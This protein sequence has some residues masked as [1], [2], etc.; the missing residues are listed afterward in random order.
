MRQYAAVALLLMEL[1]QHNTEGAARLTDIEARRRTEHVL[2]TQL[3]LLQQWG[4]MQVRPGGRGQYA[5][6]PP[7]A[8]LSPTLRRPCSQ[9]CTP[10]PAVE[11]VPGHALHY[12]IILQ[13]RHSLQCASKHI[14]GLPRC[15]PSALLLPPSVLPPPSRR[16]C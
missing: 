1:V 12:A 11:T 4:E 5:L 14:P 16:G 7:R 9:R 2:A 3:P 13:A 6:G 10:D 15:A 8:M